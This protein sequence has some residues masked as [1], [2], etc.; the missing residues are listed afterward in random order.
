[1]S[2]DQYPPINV[3]N[4]I[5]G[6]P[7]GKLKL[8]I[9]PYRFQLPDGRAFTIKKVRRMTSQNVGNFKHYHF[10]VQTRDGRFFHI[11]FDTGNV[12][13]KLVQEVDEE[14]FFND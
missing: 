2:K 4:A 14:L 6:F 13:W 8:K 9:T 7:S 3:I 1:M 12:T 10:A 11:V 5:R